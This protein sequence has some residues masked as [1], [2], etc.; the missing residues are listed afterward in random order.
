MVGVDS[1]PQ[2]RSQRSSSVVE[3]PFFMS[4]PDTDSDMTSSESDRDQP[5]RTRKM[6]LRA[7]NGEAGMGSALRHK[8]GGWSPGLRKLPSTDEQ[9]TI[10]SMTSNSSEET[11][12]PA[13]RLSRFMSDKSSKRDRA[14][15]K[16]SFAVASVRQK[17]ET[18]ATRLKQQR[19]QLRR[20]HSTDFHED[21]SRGNHAPVVSV[22][23]DEPD[24]T[25]VAKEKIIYFDWDDTLCPTGFIEE[26][27]EPF[28]LTEVLPSS[29]FY[30]G[31]RKH[32]N[33][34]ES[35][36]RAASQVAHVAIVTLA[37]RPW[38][39]SSAARF[40]PCLPIEQ[41]LQEL[42]IPVYYASE[43]I[44][45]ATRYIEEEEMDL[46]VVAKRKAMSR[47]RKKVSRKWGAVS[48]VLSIGDSH[49]EAEALKD[50]VWSTLDNA[51][52]TTVRLLSNPSL[53]ELTDE[54]VFVASICPDLVSR[55]G[56]TDFHMD[57]SDDV[58]ALLS[59]L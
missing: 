14:L 53:E 41:L 32:A 46:H 19:M 12:S 43:H 59:L 45:V 40:L 49:A 57:N 17:M 23:K 7:K 31:M 4:V 29:P 27:L 24:I 42:S 25:H 16:L 33:A 48:H 3:I 1:D 26:V 58:E 10:S 50:L 22:C 9:E 36:M 5:A 8:L 2:P 51:H 56:D 39:K 15:V 55:E 44:P 6:S 13:P 18:K 52:A 11:G 54:L 37:K 20:L 47:F 28:G 35:V 34:I 21:V 30:A 38:V